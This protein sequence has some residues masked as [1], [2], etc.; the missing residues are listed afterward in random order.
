M[1]QWLLRKTK[2]DIQAKKG[3][4]Q[5]KQE[6]KFSP[7]ETL[8]IS[9]FT[10]LNEFSFLMGISYFVGLLVLTHIATRKQVEL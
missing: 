5:R 4:K 6:P 2:N 8:C 7:I 9:L 1:T 10:V 3:L